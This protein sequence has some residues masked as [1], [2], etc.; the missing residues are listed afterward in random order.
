MLSSHYF[1]NVVNR[2]CYCYNVYWVTCNCNGLLLKSNIPQPWSMS[3]TVMYL[4]A[5]LLHITFY[6]LLT[7]N[8]WSFLKPFV[9]F[10]QSNYFII[11]V[12]DMLYKPSFNDKLCWKKLYISMEHQAHMIKVQCNSEFKLHDILFSHKQC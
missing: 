7:W 6:Y 1:E 4:C 12:I 5:L 8:K 10:L 3:F 2:L 9:S 11:V